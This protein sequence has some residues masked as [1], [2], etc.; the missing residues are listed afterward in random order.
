MASSMQDRSREAELRTALARAPGDADAMLELARLLLGA[1]AVEEAIARYETAAALR[2]HDLM[3][4]RELALA[5]AGQEELL[6]ADL[7]FSRIGEAAGP[8]REALGR[9]TPTPRP[10]T[11]RPTRPGSAWS[12]FCGWSSAPP[13]AWSSRSARAGGISPAAKIG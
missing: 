10:G 5:L 4:L 2:P 13:S 6:A 11:C 12:R 3:L 9:S 1:G 7:W 8:A